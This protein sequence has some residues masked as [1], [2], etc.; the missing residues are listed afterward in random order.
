[1]FESVVV[2]R[3]MLQTFK[4]DCKVQ[5]ETMIGRVGATTDTA[6]SLYSIDQVPAHEVLALPYRALRSGNKQPSAPVAV[7]GCTDEMISHTAS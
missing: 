3:G 1:M 7:A 2:A 5:E 6:A 4:V